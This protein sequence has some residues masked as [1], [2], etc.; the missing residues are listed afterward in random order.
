MID[1]DEPF[2]NLLCQGMVK[3]ENGDTMSKSKGNVVP[4]SSVIDPYGADTMRLAIL[5]IA[6]PEKDFDG[7]E[8]AVAGANRFIKRAWNVVWQLCQGA[9][10]GEVNPAK[11]SSSAAG[12]FRT[13]NGMGVKCTYDF[14]RGQFNTAISAI[15]E[16]VNAAMKYVAETPQDERDAALDWRVAHDIVTTLAPICPHWSEELFH[17]A[18][19]LE[20]SAYNEP[21]PEFDPELAKSDSVEIAVQIMGKVRAHVTVAVDATK[22]EL[23][24]EALKVVANQLEGKNVV[25]VIVVPG[26]LVNIVAK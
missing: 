9:E 18:L 2:T 19:H 13:L 11:L 23:Q 3:D 4:P 20:G 24:A 15:M 7:E 17:E 6:P 16:M 5:F 14:D 8:K 12:M 10:K 1:A 21:W 25:K 26:R 22:D